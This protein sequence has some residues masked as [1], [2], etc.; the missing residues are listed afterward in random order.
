MPRS[1]KER[2]SPIGQQLEAVAC[3]KR[4]NGAVAASRGIL[5]FVPW[6]ARARQSSDR[7]VERQDFVLQAEARHEPGVQDREIGRVDGV[8][9][10]NVRFGRLVDEVRR[11]DRVQIQQQCVATIGRS[12][13]HQVFYAIFRR[14]EE[15]IDGQQVVEG[16]N[17]LADEFEFGRQRQSA[18]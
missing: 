18:R 1:R 14:V 10:D 16:G 13:R 5:E 9:V 6:L 3:G 15:R 2:L 11:A 7:A 12:E 8:T 17:V 4:R